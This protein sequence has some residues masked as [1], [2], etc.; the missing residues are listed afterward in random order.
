MFVHHVRM[1]IFF[2]SHNKDKKIK[3]QNVRKGGKKWYLNKEVK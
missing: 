2:M 1:N 3:L